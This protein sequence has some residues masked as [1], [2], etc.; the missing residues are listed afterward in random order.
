MVQIYDDG[1]Y[2]T[3]NPT[4]HEEDSAWKSQQ[5]MK[6]ID[7]NTLSFNTIC[8]VGCGAGEILLNYPSNI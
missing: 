6:I 5:I 8:E 1:T 4:W 7:K 3:N 2:L